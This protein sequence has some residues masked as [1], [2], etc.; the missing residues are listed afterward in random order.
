MN[1]IDA[2]DASWWYMAQDKCGPVSTERLLQLLAAGDVS[3][4][5][6]VWRSDRSPNTAAWLALE[7]AFQRYAPSADALD[8]SRLNVTA[9]EKLTL[10]GPPHRPMAAAT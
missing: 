7:I 3:E 4:A 5:T 10:P 6:L 1:F 8:S 9:A 2:P